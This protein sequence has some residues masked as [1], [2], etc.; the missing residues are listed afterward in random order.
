MDCCF[1][2]NA[3]YY[4]KNDIKGRKMAEKCEF[5]YTDATGRE[6]S[7]AEWRMFDVQNYQGDVQRYIGGSIDFHWH[8]QMEIFL[9]ESGKVELAVG[10][11]RRT[12][13]PGEGCFI[14]A[15]QIH[16]FRALGGD[17]CRYRSM[18]F[19]PELISG[20]AGSVFDARYVQPM[21]REGAAVSF[22]SGASPKGN[23]FQRAFSSCEE[24]DT[25]Y[26]FR[27]REALSEMLLIIYKETSFGE[28][29]GSSSQ[30]EMHLKE[31]LAWIEA[32]LD[33]ETMRVSDIAEA[34][35]ISVRECQRV[36]T[37]VLHYTPMM[38]VRMQRLSRASE[39]LSGSEQTVTAIALNCGFSG[40]AYFAKLF[41]ES[42]GMCPKAFRE[43]Y[44]RNFQKVLDEQKGML[45]STSSRRE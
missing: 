37:R 44:R 39:L 3:I 11:Q 24:K 41:R 26:E 45:Y 20:G 7:Q 13:Y 16:A 12:M 33:R 28:A 18:V 17:A 40:P 36:F 34:A 10:R 1:S 9:L 25:G 31:M 19:S 14:N 15:G 5:I 32:H 2:E 30:Q 35:H 6:L 29:Q 8:E 4:E 38:Y 21:I 22:F 43:K 23:C 27:V 42:V